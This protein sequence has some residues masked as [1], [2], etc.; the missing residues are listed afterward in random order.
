[1]RMQDWHHD[2]GAILC[3]APPVIQRHVYIPVFKVYGEWNSSREH[4]VGDTELDLVF[5]FE[6]TKEFR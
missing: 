6:V 2:V 5:V 1:M 4:A 3:S